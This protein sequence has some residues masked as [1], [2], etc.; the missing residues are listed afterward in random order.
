MKGHNV[1]WLRTVSCSAIRLRVL[2]LLQVLSLLWQTLAPVWVSDWL[3]SSIAI[4]F[5]HVHGSRISA[6]PRR[7]DRSFPS[8]FGFPPRSRQGLGNG[9]GWAEF[10]FLS[11][12]NQLSPS[13]SAASRHRLYPLDSPFL[14]FDWLTYIMLICRESTN[15]RQQVCFWP[16]VSTF[17]LTS[18]SKDMRGDLSTSIHELVDVRRTTSWFINVGP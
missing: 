18:S 14:L 3:R 8:G 5:Q 17:I 4:F 2:V 6:P 16:E 13:R 9:Q 7:W 1:R 10:V 11:N 12:A 15:R